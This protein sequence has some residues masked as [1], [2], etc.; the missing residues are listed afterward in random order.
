MSN[1]IHDFSKDLVAIVAQNGASIVEIDAGHPRGASG[2]VWS[3]DGIILTA[4]HKLA[5]EEDLEVGL[6][7]G[8]RAK[9]KLL[10]VDA[11]LDLAVLKVEL[12]GLKAVTL[13]PELPAV[14]ELVVALAR[15]GKTVRAALGMVSTV[16][17]GEWRTPG[18]GRLD[19]YVESD[20]GGRVGFSG[21]LLVDADGR[22][23][24][25]NTGGLARGASLTILR[26]AL[27]R[28]V[29]AIIAHGGARRGF[30]GIAAQSIPL[31]RSLSTA[32]GQGRGL[33]VLRTEEDGPAERGGILVGDVVLSIDAQPTG[34]MRELIAALDES[35]IDKE[36]PL[37]VLR[38]GQ[39]LEVSVKVEAKR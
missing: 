37:R 5:R 15:P 8:A 9:A 27:E 23:L 38:G 1:S 3:S 26:A 4:A 11:A 10:G 21:G 24:G 33:I 16:S 12:S 29:P 31:E 28:A 22:G 39:S 32:A 30:L 25:L 2:L 36:V 34:D 18:G 6:E 20:I 14:G 35:R 7:G 19:R 17:K 13:R